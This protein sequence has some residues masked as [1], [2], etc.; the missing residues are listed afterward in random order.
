MTRFYSR[1]GDLTRLTHQY[2]GDGLTD[3]L[4]ALG[5]HFAMTEAEIRKMYGDVP[6]PLFRVHNWRAIW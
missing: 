6:L 3:I 1:A 5:T 4:P 2:Y